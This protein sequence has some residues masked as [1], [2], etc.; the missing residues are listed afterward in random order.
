MDAV[1][2]HE[3]ALV[4]RAV[5]GLC[6]IPGVTV[7][8][9]PDPDRRIGVVAFTVEGVRH[10][11][12][13]TLLNQE[14]A[15]AVRNGC[16]CAQPYL[17]RLLGLEDTAALRERLRRGDDSDLPGAVRPSFGLFN[18]EAE[19][20]VLLEVVRAIGEGRLAGRLPEPLAG[21]A[22]KEL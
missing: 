18:T 16:F 17:Y 7:L 2:A 20:D 14:A 13:A 21:S 10:E 4:A 11:A 8:G 1:R 6:A 15:I 3:R 9:D 5:S 19:V 12:V 22:C